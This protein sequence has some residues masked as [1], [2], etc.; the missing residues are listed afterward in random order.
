[1]TLGVPVG[2]WFSMGFAKGEVFVEK[3]LKG[4]YA[5]PELQIEQPAIIF[6]RHLRIAFPRELGVL[7]PEA[8]RLFL[9]PELGD[10]IIYAVIAA[11]KVGH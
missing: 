4:R 1:M 5:L 2:P 8:D 3:F 11:E 7:R 10:K 9:P 6:V